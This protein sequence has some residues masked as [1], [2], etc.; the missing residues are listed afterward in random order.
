MGGWHQSPR[1]ARSAAGLA[2]FFPLTSSSGAV[3]VP[4]LALWAPL[5]V[6]AS[7][8]PGWRGG[9]E[10]EREASVG[11]CMW[12]SRGGCCRQ[13]SASVKV[14]WWPTPW[15]IWKAGGEPGGAGGGP[16]LTG[17]GVGV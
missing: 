17:T 4:C 7:W 2:P 5:A 1:E 3:L 10:D 13:S 15:P 8:R 16:V 11:L 6:P 9:A 12:P 14:L